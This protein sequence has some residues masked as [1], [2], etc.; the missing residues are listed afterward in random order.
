MQ[1]RAALA[2]A[3]V[4]AGGALLSA[5]IASRPQATFRAEVNYVE[6]D[7]V[8]TDAQGRFVPGLTAAD[9]ELLDAGKPQAIEAFHEVNVPVERA[10]RMLYSEATVHPDV[11]SNVA[12]GEGRVYLIVLDDLH[13]EAGDTNHVRRRAREF[14]ERYV[15]SN[16]LAAVLHTSGRSSRSQDFTSNRAL[17]LA[18]IDGFVGMG[19]RSAVLNRVDD[20]VR[21]AGSELSGPPRDID[22][23]ERLARAEGVFMTVRNL[24]NYMASLSGRRKAMLLFSSGVDLDS[25]SVV[26][27]SGARAFQELQDVRIAMIEAVAAATRANVHIYTVDAAGIAEAGMGASVQGLQ[28]PE[29]GMDTPS[30]MTERRN[31]QGTLRTIADQTGGYA[32]VNTNSFA[33]GYA[34][35][36]REN[37]TYYLLGFYPSTDRDGKFH[38]LTVRVT[39]PGLQVRARSGYHALKGSAPAP[40]AGAHELDAMVKAAVPAPGLPMRLSLPAFKQSAADAIVLMAIDVPAE[41]FR[42]ETSGEIAAEDFDVLY[43]V[44]EPGSKV[45]ASASQNVE[46]RLRADTRARIEQRGFRA[47]FPFTVK[48]GRYQVRA[49][50]RTKNGARKGSVFADLVVPD[51]FEP[52]LV[53]SGVALTSAAA[54]AIPTRPAG[55]DTAA[56]IPLMPSAVRTFAAG[57]TLALYAEAYD[58][59]T[60]AAHGVD[61]TAAIRDETGRVVFTTSE[62]R[63]SAE[64]GGGRGGYGFRV[65]IPLTLPPGSYVLTLTARSRASGNATAARDIP[66][67]IS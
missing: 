56:L 61:L 32:I 66:F 34:R 14:V 3:L 4:A 7:V 64:L 38:R 18:A 50:A 29:P 44:I 22:A 59:D 15:G 23:R 13:T 41:V 19:L 5:Q 42:F 20:A 26:D 48:P 58:N 2:A 21:M 43:Q 28:R 9:F 11:A 24:A 31:A 67:A 25:Q 45:V 17:L 16:D 55:D 65:D 6:V 46:M 37:S 27:I 35:I 60:R 47:I 52:R 39:R 10:D 1:M 51:F 12:A 63:S 8:V 36:L 54:A 62:E 57:D 53:W 30:L 40:P 49:A 33:D